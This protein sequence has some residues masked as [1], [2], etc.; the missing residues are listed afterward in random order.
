M[1][2]FVHKKKFDFSAPSLNLNQTKYPATTTQKTNRYFPHRRRLHH[3][4]KCFRQRHRHC[5]PTVY[6]ASAANA[7]T[8]ASVAV[9]DRP[10]KSLQRPTTA[11]PLQAM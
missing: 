11:Q 4:R 9:T 10:L 1:L 2:Y 8:A 6:T 7:A 3:R 5:Q